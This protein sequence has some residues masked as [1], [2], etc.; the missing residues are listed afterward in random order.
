MTEDHKNT[1]YKT[2]CNVNSRRPLYK[3]RWFL[4]QLRS[5]IW[6][7]WEGLGH[8]NHSLLSCLWLAVSRPNPWRL[9]PQWVCCLFER[10]FP[11]CWT[12]PNASVSITPHSVTASNMMEGM[13]CI[14]REW[15][16]KLLTEDESR[17]LWLEKLAKPHPNISRKTLPT[18]VLIPIFAR[19]SL[20]PISSVPCCQDGSVPSRNREPF[21]WWP[22]CVWSGEEGCCPWWLVDTSCVWSGEEGCCPDD[23]LPFF[24]YRGM[25]S[26]ELT[27]DGQII[28]RRWWLKM[29]KVMFS[30][31]QAWSVQQQFPSSH[32]LRY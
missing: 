3:L 28:W 25:A 12:Q 8:W 6:K 29:D 18:S 5:N 27:E 21:G 1:D 4:R 10:T 30:D 7:D 23:Y 11:E 19:K 13:V 17:R 14:A 32:C 31:R 2:C 20:L 24:V 22:W 9:R 26:V 15:W 16:N